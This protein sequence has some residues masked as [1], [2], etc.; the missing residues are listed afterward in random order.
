LLQ[1]FSGHIDAISSVSFSPDGLSVASAGKDAT[2]RLWDVATGQ[3][4]RLLA[5]YKGTIWRVK[6]YPNGLPLA[7]DL[8]GSIGDFENENIRLW[9]LRTG[10]LKKRLTGHASWVTGISFS[11]DGET[12]ASVSFDDTVLLWDLTS[13]IKVLDVAE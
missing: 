4:K 5:G 8:K 6:F 11:A 10:Q 3:Q 7:S 9:D 12:L 2:V 1:T 13:T